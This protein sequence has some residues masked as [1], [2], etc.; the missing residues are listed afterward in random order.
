MR[1]EV[2]EEHWRSFLGKIVIKEASSGKSYIFDLS[3]MSN[4][5]EAKITN[6][7]KSNWLLYRFKYVRHIVLN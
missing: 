6:F 5:H 4:I 3:K 7:S 1:F 2:R